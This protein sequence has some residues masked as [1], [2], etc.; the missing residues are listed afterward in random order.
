VER[1]GGESRTVDGVAVAGAGECRAVHSAGGVF[2]RDRGG[3]AR[4]KSDAQTP[5]LDGVADVSGLVAS[6]G[7]SWQVRGGR[8]PRVAR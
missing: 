6:D 1:E 7:P 3:G 5:E 8:R 4:L 2:V